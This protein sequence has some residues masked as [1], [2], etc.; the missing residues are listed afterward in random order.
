VTVDEV[1]DWL[2]ETGTEENREGM[3]RYAVPNDRAFGVTVGDMRDFAKRHGT[4]HELALELWE[5]GWYEAR[6]LAAMLADPAALTRERMDAWVG[7]LDS[8]AI[9]D[10]VC[11]HLFDRTAHAWDAIPDWAAS[12]EEYTR[13]AGFA[14]VWALSVHDRKAPDEAFLACL[15]LVERHAGDDR[16][17]V[18][19][20]ID[21]AL[22]AVGKRNAALNSAA[23]ETAKRLAER[24]EPAASWIGRHAGK[25]LSSEK[26]RA[27]LAKHES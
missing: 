20:A 1:L 14:L 19:K 7:D 22:R 27:R 6:T 3:L 15:P 11:F 9:T 4:D 8:W 23:L 5:T 12:E 21:M 16:R 18:K 10:T 13:R 24:E 17:Y 2:N 26:V 25:E